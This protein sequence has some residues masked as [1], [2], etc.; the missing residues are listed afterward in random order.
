MPYIVPVYKL[1]ATRPPPSLSIPPDPSDN[2]DAGDF[3]VGILKQKIAAG[4]PETVDQYGNLTTQAQRELVDGLGINA[5]T[6]ELL[7]YLSPS[8]SV[9]FD[10]DQYGRYINAELL[11]SSDIAAQGTVQGL[12]YF[13]F[14]TAYHLA[15]AGH[16]IARAGWALAADAAPGTEPSGL[17]S[18]WLI[19][20]DGA[21]W[22]VVDAAGRLLVTSEDDEEPITAN[23][24]A[25]DLLSRDWMLPPDCNATVTNRPDFPTDSAAS[26][27]PKFNVFDPPCL[28]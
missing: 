10:V 7:A 26:T 16:P 18:K 21:A 23:I 8:S 25:V 19:T 20:Y 13:N 1:S 17:P 27:P 9:R 24:T 28:V 11:T 4:D 15:L 3:R 12:D 5:F 2:S 6:D 14:P 22:F